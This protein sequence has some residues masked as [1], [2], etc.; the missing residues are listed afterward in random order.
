MYGEL[1]P[2]KVYVSRPG[3]LKHKSVIH[4]VGP[5]WNQVYPKKA[6]DELKAAVFSALIEADTRM[7]KS[8][9]MPL[10]SCGVYGFPAEKAAQ[11]ISDTVVEF[12]EVSAN[13]KEVYIVNGDKAK[14]D[15]TEKALIQNSGVLMQQKASATSGKDYRFIFVF[16]SELIFSNPF[17]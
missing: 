13:L 10:I 17:Y 8:V 1:R 5:I 2:G 11:I 12:L 16:S 9:V 6:N 14:L 4:T 15:I 3:K 7:N